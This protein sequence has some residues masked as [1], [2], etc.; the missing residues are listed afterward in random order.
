MPQAIPSLTSLLSSPNEHTRIAG[1]ESLA[2]IGNAECLA[3]IKPL[4]S[5]PAPNVSENAAYWVREL[6]SEAQD[7]RVGTAL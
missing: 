1:I 4:Q 2:E 6:E 3:L 7:A 5:D